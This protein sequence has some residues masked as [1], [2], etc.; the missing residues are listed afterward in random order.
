MGLPSILNRVARTN[1][2]N[3]HLH[4]GGFTV[5]GVSRAPNLF[6]LCRAFQ[7]LHGEAWEDRGLPPRKRPARTGSGSL[8]GQPST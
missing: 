1:A 2:V 8:E 4:R 5:S 7:H 6:I 3:A